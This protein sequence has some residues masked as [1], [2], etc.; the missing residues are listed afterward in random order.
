MTDML[1]HDDKPEKVYVKEL[2]TSIGRII[3][4]I[5]TYNS[6]SP[7]LYDMVEYEMRTL[8][9]E[10]C[11][12]TESHWINVSFNAQQQATSNMLRAAFAVSDLRTQ[13]EKE[14]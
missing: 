4:H 7:I 13:L 3:H 5:Q 11:K 8:V 10:L 1:F 9:N 2:Y 6:S 12:K 14:K